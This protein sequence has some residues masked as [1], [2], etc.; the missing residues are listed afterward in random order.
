M[1]FSRCSV[2]SHGETGGYGVYKPVQFTGL[3]DTGVALKVLGI[4]SNSKVLLFLR[5]RNL[6]EMS[7]FEP[8]TPCLQGRCSP[9]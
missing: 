9:S 8:L 3:S 7:G 5:E 1:Q 6:V 2:V 4:T